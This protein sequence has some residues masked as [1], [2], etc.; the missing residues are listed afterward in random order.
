LNEGLGLTLVLVSH[1]I[2]KVVQEAMHI[3]CID[4]SLVCHSSPEEFLMDSPFKNIL[5]HNIKIIHH[6]H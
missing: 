1:D 6:H 5:G 2:E 4:T 3:A